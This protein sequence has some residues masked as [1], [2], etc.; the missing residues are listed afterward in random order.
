[1]PL[2][3]SRRNQFQPAQKRARKAELRPDT[4]D[5]KR[6]VPRSRLIL[7]HGLFVLLLLYLLAG[8]GYQQLFHFRDHR[9]NEARQNYRRIL[10]PGPRGN[11][12]DREGRLLVGNRPVFKAVVSLNELRPEFRAEYYR[13]ADEARE[14]QQQIN[15]LEL[16]VESRRAVVQRYLDRLNHLLGRQEEVNSTVLER[17][18]QQTLLL[19]FTLLSDLT[20]EDYARLIEQVPVESPVQ[21]IAESARFYPHGAAASHVLGFVSSTDDIRTEDVPG[22]D[23]LTFKFEGKVGRSGLERIYDEH[24]QGRSGGEVWSVDPGGFQHERIAFRSPVKGNDLVTTIDLDVQL[25]AEQALGERMGAAV[26]IRVATGEVLALASKPDYDLND[27]TP[28]LSFAV[29]ER[30]REEGGWLNRATQ[31]LYAPGSTFKIV[32]AVAGMRAGHIDDETVIDCP[33]HF[34]VGRRRFHCHRRAGHGPVDIVDSIRV[35]CNV[36]FYDRALRMGVSALAE[37]ARRFG[38]DSRTGIELFGETG[39]MLVPDPAWKEERLYDNW[40]DGDTANM[41]IGQGFLK[42]TPLQVATFTAS[43][44]R[45]ETRTYPTLVQDPS[46]RNPHSESEP[47]DPQIVALIHAGM[48]E[49]GAVG[50]A[51]LAAQAAGVSV[52]GKTGTAQAH[53]DGEPTTIAWFMGFA[54]AENPEI[55]VVVALE[56]VPAEATDYAGGA[57]AAP[58]AGEV[59]RAYSRKL[60][61]DVVHH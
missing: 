31:G 54:P 26:A 61:P 7:L 20:P 46:M 57:H 45:G 24:L 15:R 56:G 41:S 33:G 29:D 6:H 27:L 30:I 9:E 12:F 3:H 2:L 39:M 42:V 50:T 10:T 60:Q 51:R 35:S 14:I 58:I 44:A 48:R 22:D 16:N 43:V 17:H 55:A 36:F 49:A 37:E 19:P 23:L 11:I 53:K 4:Q 8:L 5:P 21:V 52:A 28:F 18:F 32:T 47:L 40:Y 59:I 13:R 1:M 34:L 25:A 38:F